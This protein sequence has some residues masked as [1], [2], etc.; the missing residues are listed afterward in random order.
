MEQQC[1]IIHSLN[2]ANIS[3][4]EKR[5]VSTSVCVCVRVRVRASG[6]YVCV[7]ASGWYACVSVFRFAKAQRVH[8]HERFL[9]VLCLW[10][11]CFERAHLPHRLHTTSAFL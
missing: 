4:E 10:P 6:W 3:R 5:S 11:S 8:F 2:P 7:R 1:L 9:R